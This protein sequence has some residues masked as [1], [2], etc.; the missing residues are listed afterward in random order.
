M[1]RL[2]PNVASQLLGLNPALPKCMA[3][4]ANFAFKFKESASLGL[5]KV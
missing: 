3:Y 1:G 4:T 5:P 2:G